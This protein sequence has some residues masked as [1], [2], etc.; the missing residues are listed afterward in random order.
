MSNPVIGVPVVGVPVTDQDRAIEFYT[1]AFGFTTRTDTPLPQ[2]GSRWIVLAPP[3]ADA[4][5]T[6]IALVQAGDG[7]PAGVETGIRLAVADAAAKHAELTD[8]GVPVGELLRWP[9]TPPMFTVTDQDGNG[10]EVIEQ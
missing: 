7:L 10:L 2:L 4:A 8:R 1:E 3:G 9:G 5:A 6:G